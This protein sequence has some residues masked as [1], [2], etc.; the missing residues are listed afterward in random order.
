MAVVLYL[1]VA[2]FSERELSLS[3]I[4]L[5]E[6]ASGALLAALIVFFALPSLLYRG[7]YFAFAGL[8][9]AG[10][11][12]TGS[13]NEWVLDPL[14]FPAGDRRIAVSRWG[15]L[16][17]MVSSFSIAAIVAM[18]DNV[19]YQRKLRHLGALRTEAELAAL[20]NQLNP[21]IVLNAL[22]NVYA[23][24]LERDDRAPDLVLML[25]NV[26]RYSLYEADHGS[27]TLEREV[28]ML[29]SYVAVQALGMGD[30]AQITF[31]VEGDLE[32]RQILPLLLLPLVENAFKHGGAVAQ[33]TPLDIQ[34]KL[35]VHQD[36]IEFESSNPYN[37]TAAAHGEGGIGLDNLRDRLK[38]AYPERHRLSTVAQGAV[39]RV[40]LVVEGEPG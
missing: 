37:S 24:T 14:I 19:E 33:T 8:C 32:H 4:D 10:V 17:A 35:R 16:N 25:S 22:N 30:R 9:V 21:H 28:E 1:L 7:H 39:F 31:D 2:T 36:S 23:L 3:G 40:A 12:L 34:F 20:K 18:F 38:L 29:K 6:A 5:A 13:L 26:L 11:V 15:F 27:A